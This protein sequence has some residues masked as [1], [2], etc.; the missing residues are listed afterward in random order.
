VLL[1]GGVVEEEGE[2]VGFYS[3]GGWKLMIG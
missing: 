2:R 3:L 1:L